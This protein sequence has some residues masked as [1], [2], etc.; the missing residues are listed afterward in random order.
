VILLLSDDLLDASK[1]IANGR[2]SGISVLQCKSL[3]AMI[4]QLVMQQV[5]CCIVDLQLHGLSIEKLIDAISAL[6]AKPRVI[7]YGSHVDAAR[8]QAA[9]KAGC[10]QVMPRSQYFEV[11]PEKIAEWD[12]K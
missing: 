1:T 5:D 8:L 4:E 2:A 12:S 11:M 3:P 6:P 9:R 10:Q 7:A